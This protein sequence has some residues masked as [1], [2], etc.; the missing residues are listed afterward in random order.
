MFVD[1]IDFF[2]FL[3]TRRVRPGL[4]WVEGGG[5]V[6]GVTHGD[7]VIGNP[8]LMVGEARVM[9]KVFRRLPVVLLVP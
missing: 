3:L 7:M 1:S 5:E 2:N 8:R 4:D 6:E 9:I